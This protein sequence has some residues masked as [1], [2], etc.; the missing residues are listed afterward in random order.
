MQRSHKLLPASFCCIFFKCM[1]LLNCF[2]SP[3]I[4]LIPH[5]VPHTLLKKCIV[6]T[7]SLSPVFFTVNWAW[8]A[9]WW[10]IKMHKGVSLC[11][12]LQPQVISI[13]MFIDLKIN[14]FNTQC[15][16]LSVNHINIMRSPCQVP[17]DSTFNHLNCITVHVRCFWCVNL[18]KS[19]SV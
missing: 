6:E 7:S 11:S 10:M 17:F 3:S 16:W 12:S 18:A 8:T 5:R 19:L 15:C 1:S 13:T 4:P 9:I 2:F 14:T